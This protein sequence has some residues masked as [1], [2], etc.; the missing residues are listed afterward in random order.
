MLLFKDTNA[1]TDCLVDILRLLVTMHIR[2]Y[3]SKTDSPRPDEAHSMT[4][5]YLNRYKR[6][7]SSNDQQAVLD[8]YVCLSQHLLF[9]LH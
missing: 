2:L 9:N 7:H 8:A 1:F 4:Y 5:I 6:F 3:R